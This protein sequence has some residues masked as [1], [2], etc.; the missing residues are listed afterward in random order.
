ME[1]PEQ[2]GPTT[3]SILWPYVDLWCIRSSHSAPGAPCERCGAGLGRALHAESASEATTTVFGSRSSY[4][5]PHAHARTCS[6][7]VKKTRATWREAGGRG[8]SDA[9]EGAGRGRAG[10][11]SLWSLIISTASLKCSRF[12]TP[13]SRSPCVDAKSPPM[14]SLSST[15]V[16][17][18]CSRPSSQQDHNLDSVT[19]VCP[20]QH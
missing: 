11:P 17:P 6:A 20:R 3:A 18:P 16:T 13:P 12:S 5:L 9:W 4:H 8:R 7:C 1:A 10:Y 14:Y 2:A 19:T 15:T